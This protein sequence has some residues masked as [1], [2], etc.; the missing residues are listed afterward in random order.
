[1]QSLAK[2]IPIQENQKRSER[3]L[4]RQQKRPEQKAYCLLFIHSRVSRLDSPAIS[5]V[6]LNEAADQNQNWAI[7]IAKTFPVSPTS[8]SAIADTARK[9][10]SIRSSSAHTRQGS[11]IRLCRS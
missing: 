7:R 9:P 3:F 4:L 1:M 5:S 8:Q 2:P 10:P 11:T 6:R